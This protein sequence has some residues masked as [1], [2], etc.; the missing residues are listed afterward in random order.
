MR[1]LASCRRGWVL[2]PV[3]V[4]TLALGS[5]PAAAQ[6]RYALLVE[7][8][9]GEPQFAT[10]HRGWLDQIK[11]LLVDRFKL[12]SARLVVLS[13]KP[14]A[15]EVR[16]TAENL[17]AATAR[18]AT[19]VKSDDLVFVMLIGHGS[20][21]T[22]E[23][24]FNLIG[25]DLSAAEWAGLLKPI[26]GRLVFVNTTSA[27]FPYLQGLSA[28]G[29]VVITATR[30]TAERFHTR[31]AESFIRALAAAEADADKN[32]RISLWE[33]FTYAT[34]LVAQSFEQDDYKI[35]EHALLDDNGDGQGS[36]GATGGSDGSVAG[37]TYLDLEATP[38]S[39][40]PAVQALIA[41][42]TALTRQVEDLRRRRT[43]LPPAIFDQQF[44]A[45]IIELATVS[46]DVRRR[47]GG[48]P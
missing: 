48:A 19:Q 20:A 11:T 23:A 3:F 17:R 14:A 35:T 1:R 32:R 36:D 33:A 39:S 6:E 43:G 29:R 7:G 4:A 37:L 41:R 2:V 27:S 34:R 42:Q 10:L 22:G 31:F 38:T 24:K 18:L 21:Q 25:P 47:T 15:G 28:P 30:S 9:P 8:A 26:P 46:R 40:D 44:E 45:L 12:D 13:D 16:A 5:R